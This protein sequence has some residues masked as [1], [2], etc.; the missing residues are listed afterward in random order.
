MLHADR[1]KQVKR[2]RKAQQQP[3]EMEGD[4][5]QASESGVF[6]NV[7]SH[8]DD[9]IDLLDCITNQE[10]M[11]EAVNEWLFDLELEGLATGQPRDVSVGGVVFKAPLSSIFGTALEALSDNNFD[12]I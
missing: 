3:D 1:P 5:E 2:V 8:A 7:A 11:D 6:V 12:T 10:E 4:E 9:N